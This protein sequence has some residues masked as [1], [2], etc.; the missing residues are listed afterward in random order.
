ML[1]SD[2]GGSIRGGGG[3]GG[4]YC[5][6]PACVALEHRRHLH[7][8]HVPI[9][10]CN[11]VLC[12]EWRLCCWGAASKACNDECTV[13]VNTIGHSGH[14]RRCTTAARAWWWP[15]VNGDGR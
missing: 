9:A 2:G 3:G 14:G 13:Y 4:M 1:S 6:V 7:Y 15:V 11:Y 5:C 8:L 10:D 12:C